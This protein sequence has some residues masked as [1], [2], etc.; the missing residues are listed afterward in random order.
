[1]I[2]TYTWARNDGWTFVV[3][4]ANGNGAEYVQKTFKT[5]HGAQKAAERFVELMD[6]WKNTNLQYTKTDMKTG[7]VTKVFKYVNGQQQVK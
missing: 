5:R 3:A 1:M 6:G 7:D 4:F 2:N